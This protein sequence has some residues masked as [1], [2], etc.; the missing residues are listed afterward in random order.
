MGVISTFGSTILV[1]TFWYQHFG[2]NI[3]VSTFW[4]QHFG[5]NNLASTYVDVFGYPT[6]GIHVG[7]IFI[8]HK[9]NQLES[10]SF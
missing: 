10:A 7:M 3:L 5:I 6:D 4:Y 8:R 2:I 1:S 9:N